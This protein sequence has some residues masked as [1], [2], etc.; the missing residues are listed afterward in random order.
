[1]PTTTIPKKII[2][3]GEYTIVPRKAYEEFL[4]WQKKVKS[5]RTFRPTAR[6]KRVLAN[7]RKNFLKGNYVTLEQLRHELGFDN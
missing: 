5:A 2:Y 4:E 1:M 6:D 3:E 7:A